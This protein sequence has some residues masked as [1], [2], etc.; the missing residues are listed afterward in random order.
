MLRK[1]W[2]SSV[3]NPFIVEE[4]LQ[5]MVGGGQLVLG[6]RGWRE[7]ESVRTEIPPTLVRRDQPARRPARAA[8]QGA[9]VR[10]GRARHP[11]PL[12]MVQK[13]TGVDDHVLVSELQAS[14]SGAAGLPPTNAART[15]TP[16][17]TR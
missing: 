9:A 7:V 1:V 8:G 14:V 2:E 3:G 12:S 17:S 5:G 11:V 15:G 13:I 4:L 10:G 16:S 6:A